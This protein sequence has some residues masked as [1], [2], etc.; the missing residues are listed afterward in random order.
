MTN[1]I[2]L[3]PLGSVLFPNM[4]LKLHIFEERYKTMINECIERNEPFG[5]VLI[6]SGVE[7]LGPLAEPH[8]IGCTAQISQVQRLPY[9]RMNILAT[10]QERFRILQIHRDESY[11][12]GDVEFMPYV[13]H[14]YKT[15]D[16]QARLLRPLIHRYLRILEDAGQLQ[17]EAN[18]IPSDAEALGYLGAVLL[19]TEAEEKQVLLEQPDMDALLFTLVKQYQREVMLL[20]IMLNPPDEHAEDTP[21]SRN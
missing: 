4:P 2:P 6:Q 18:Q 1:R 21:F 11:L 7:A 17:F 12:T 10:G 8:M 5:V 20:D 15:N 9:G 19:Q 3:F 16:A 14:D 13:S